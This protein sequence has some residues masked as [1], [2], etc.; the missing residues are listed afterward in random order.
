VADQIYTPG[1]NDAPLKYTV[2][3]TQRMIPRAFQALFDGSGASGDFVPAVVIRSQAGHV[4]A[5]AIL[6]S[7]I[8]AGDGAEVS[9]FPGVKHAGTTTATTTPV[10]F[11]QYQ[12]TA[13]VL[14]VGTTHPPIASITQTVPGVVTAGGA[15]PNPFLVNTDGTYLFQLSCFVSNANATAAAIQF[16]FDVANAPNFLAAQPILIARAI[17]A[18]GQPFDP[19]PNGSLSADVFGSFQ[20]ECDLGI[21][22]SKT[23]TV[24]SVFLVVSQTSTGQIA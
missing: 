7:T 13:G 4:I 10:A 9:W 12:D 22:C 17:P 8:T 2:P 6:D 20:N 23:L 11:V 14:P 24:S 15:G 19:Q 16:I 21:V 18:A 1:P 3:G 5:R